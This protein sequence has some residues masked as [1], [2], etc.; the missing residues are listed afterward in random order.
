MRPSVS[1]SSVTT[2][3]DIFNRCIRQSI[4][5]LKANEQFEDILPP[6]TICMM[7]I[8]LEA[9]LGG[10]LDPGAKQKYLENFTKF[11]KIRAILLIVVI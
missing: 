3:L 2:Q 11:V 1:L 5:S 10:D 7:N 4:A 6:I 9:C 8:F